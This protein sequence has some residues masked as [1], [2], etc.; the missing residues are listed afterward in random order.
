MALSS[1]G[2]VVYFCEWRSPASFHGTL[3]AFILPQN[4]P[5]LLKVIQPTIKFATKIA[6]DSTTMS[7]HTTTASKISSAATIADT[8]SGTY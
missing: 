8:R 4:L 7:N 2:R 6:I 3:I 5:I 1:E